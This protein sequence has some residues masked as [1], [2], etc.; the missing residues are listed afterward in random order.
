MLPLFLFPFDGHL[1]SAVIVGA[2]LTHHYRWHR[3]A[4]VRRLERLVKRDRARLWIVPLLLVLGATS[5]RAQTPLAGVRAI[6]LKDYATQI[7]DT[8][9]VATCLMRKLSDRGPFTFPD[10]PDTADAVLALTATVPT[11]GK[12]AWGA[13]PFVVGTLTTRDG[14]VLWEGKNNLKK[15]TTAWGAKDMECGLAD[16]LARKITQAIE[17]ASRAQ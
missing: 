11:A 15:A 13:Q 12:R 17:K 14:A 1:L 4:T 7:G 16:G 10:T 8:R 5:A 6:H 9:A 3:N 2:W